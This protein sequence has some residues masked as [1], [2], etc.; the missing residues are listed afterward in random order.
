M[1]YTDHVTACARS[2]AYENEYPTDK[3]LHILI[4]MQGVAENY[5]Y[6]LSATC[7]L[8]SNDIDHFSRIGEHFDAFETT[9]LDLK[10]SLAPVLSQSGIF[11]RSFS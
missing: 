8:S 10:N 7:A 9:L 6:V 3:A 4:S 2:L 11:P 5:H 1:P